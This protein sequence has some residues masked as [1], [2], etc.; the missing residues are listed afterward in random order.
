MLP[1][2]PADLVVGKKYGSEGTAQ[3]YLCALMINGPSY[4]YNKTWPLS[5]RGVRFVAALYE[6]TFGTPPVGIP[7]FWN[8]LDGIES[9][10]GPRCAG[11]D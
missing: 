11:L 9:G 3:R 8:E 5:D 2:D 4:G 6:A 10:F 7:Q 1:E